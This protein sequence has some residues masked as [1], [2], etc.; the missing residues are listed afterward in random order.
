MNFSWF[1]QDLVL[2]FL[3]RIPLLIL[4]S[5]FYAAGLKLFI[6]PNGLFDNG[7]TGIAVVIY[8]FFNLPLGILFILINLPFWFIGYK[9]ID[10]Y[11]TILTIISVFFL[12]IF[13]ESFSLFNIKTIHAITHDLLLASI[14]GG[15]FLGIGVG[16]IIRN[17]SSF[18]GVEAISIIL[19]KKYSFTIGEMALFFNFFI[20]LFAGIFFGL[21]KTMYS[22]IS[23]FICSR[24]IDIT[25]EGFNQ[26]K[27][28]TIISDKYDEISTVLM[29][30]MGK[31]VTIL[32][33]KGGYSKTEKNMIYM[34]VSRFEIGS[35]KN[36]VK[37]IDENAII[38]ISDVHEVMGGTIHKKKPVK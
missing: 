22:L 18:D 33:A 17:N 31:R 1:K 15:I 3:R 28:V 16:L 7:T 34:I 30:E 37:I 14:F 12:S 36:I 23:Y 5:L 9:H 13:I 25:V 27:N 10:K 38:I 11:F 2:F 21:D 32:S 24:T 6:L 4:G 26:V 20:L 19:S 35:I 29:L 8:Y